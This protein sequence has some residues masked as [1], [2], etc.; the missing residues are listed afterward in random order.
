MIDTWFGDPES[1][2]LGFLHIPEGGSARG[3]VVLCPPLGHEQVI[4]YRAM[5]FLG[6]TLAANGVAALRFDYLGEGDASGASAAED[7]VE[8]WLASI[9][10]AVQYLKDSGVERIALVGLTSGALLAAEA[11]R[12]LDDISGLV[13]WDPA[14]SGRRFLRRQRSIHDLAVGKVSEPTPER[15]ALLS[16]TIHGRTAEWL[17]STEITAASLAASGVETLLVGRASD[18]ANSATTKLLAALP[19]TV[20]YRSVTGQE[21]LLDV[22]SSIAEIPAGTIESIASW[23]RNRFPVTTRPVT[24][25]VRTEA[26]VG[27]TA[28]G[29]P[30]IERLSRFGPERLFTI[31][32]AT[33]F[34]AGVPDSRGVV[35]MQPAAAE[36]RI[37]PGRFQ[38]DAARELAERGYRAVR[39][40]RR[41][42][43]DTT[44]VVAAEPNMVLA[45]EWVEDAAALTTAYAHGSPIAL[46]GLCSGAWV[47][48]RIA[49]RTEA[50]LTVLLDINYYRTTPLAP[51]EYA[52]RARMDQHGEPQL[53]RFRHRLR[54]IIPGWLWRAMSF[55]QVF[56]DPTQLLSPPTRVPGST[57][58]LLLTPEDEAVF[59]KNKG[60]DAVARLRE[61]GG[62]IRITTYDFGDHALFGDGVR[63]AIM[64][65]TI[66]LVESSIPARPVPA[67]QS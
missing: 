46:V 62:D 27:I 42:S 20:E 39:F 59:V 45:K 63:A 25:T 37:G 1:P 14:L 64:Q 50:R 29:H 17:E 31:E 28:D 65:D 66:A 60:A 47:S 18:A 23:L 58:A 26:V 38:V 61:R 49:E 21:A 56:N 52:Q 40:D 3:G 55:T 54:E 67:L 9:R 22:A 51:G 7:S 10:A 16:L 12:T 44:E 2:T 4:A 35:I 24:A 34:P 57:I 53:G 41:I 15:V 13:L 8:R 48:A 32:T 6:Q 30:I 11:L 36:H 5:R 33:S 43:G 19:S